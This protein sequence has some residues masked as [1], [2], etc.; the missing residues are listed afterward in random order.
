[1]KPIMFVACTDDGCVERFFCVSGKCCPEEDLQVV[2]V[3]EEEN[4]TS[5]YT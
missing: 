1:M 5:E 3:D 4:A 2:E